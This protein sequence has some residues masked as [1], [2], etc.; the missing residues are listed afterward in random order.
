[1]ASA[2]VPGQAVPGQTPR[3][4]A[5]VA[6]ALGAVDRRPVIHEVLA[7]LTSRGWVTEVDDALHLT[8]EGARVHAAIAPLIDEVREQVITALPGDDCVTLA[9]LL[10]R[11][12][13]S[14]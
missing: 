14:L 3:G 4:E 2:V 7:Q 5:E 12:T 13:A 6:E 1:M 11:L 10:Q 9:R 8:K